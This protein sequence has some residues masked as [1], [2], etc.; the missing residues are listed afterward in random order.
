MLDVHPPE[1]GVHGAR[2][3]LVH[4]LMITLGLLIALG[5]EQ[6][7]EALHH[8]HQRKEAEALIREEIRD[9]IAQLEDGKKTLQSEIDGMKGLLSYT[10]A[11]V[12]GQPADA[13]KLRPSLSEG[14]LKDAA[15]RTASATGVLGY[16]DYATAEKFSACY[17]E[18][19]EFE[20]MDRRLVEDYLAVESNV[21]VKRLPDLD[22]DELRQAIPGMRK[23]LADLGGT[24]D[25]GT[26]LLEACH[27]A[28]Q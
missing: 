1:H 28:V 6:A 17:K 3:F 23:T 12:S 22:N 4:M 13:S 5:L 14:L 9:N 11:R 26:G 25:V 15:W 21:A 20:L 19:D 7:A 27:E 8:R 18:V 10:E 24:R 2:D 16:M